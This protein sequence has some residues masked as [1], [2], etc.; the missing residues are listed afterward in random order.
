MSSIA[1]LPPCLGPP[2]SGFW[3][4]TIDGVAFTTACAVTAPLPSWPKLFWPQQY[5][6][7][8]SLEIAQLWEPDPVPIPDAAASAPL[9]P[10]TTFGVRRMR[11]VVPIWPLL[12]APQHTTSLALVTPQLWAKPELS[13]VKE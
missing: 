5:T 13:C 8:R 12:F 3:P 7:S 9:M 4:I 11:L 2:Q 1:C 6:V 10:G